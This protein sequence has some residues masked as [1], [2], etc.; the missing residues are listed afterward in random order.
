MALRPVGW[1]GEARKGETIP[2]AGCLV[3]RS[4]FSIIFEALMIPGPMHD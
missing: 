4:P 2:G 3:G 1:L